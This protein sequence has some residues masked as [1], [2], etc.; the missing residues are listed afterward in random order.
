M[1]YCC[2]LIA[3]SW[4]ELFGVVFTIIAGVWTLW[5]WRKDRR[6]R[7]ADIYGQLLSIFTDNDIFHAFS[8]LIDYNEIRE[9]DLEKSKECRDGRME[10][11]DKVLLFLNQVCYLREN[12]MMS[13]KEVQT[14]RYPLLRTLTNET[15]LSYIEGLQRDIDKDFMFDSLMAYA[16]TIGKTERTESEEVLT[17]D[18]WRGYLV[19]HYGGWTHVAESVA[20]RVNTICERSGATI[21][22]LV[23]TVEIAKDYLAKANQLFPDKSSAQIASFRTAIRHCCNAKH[24]VWLG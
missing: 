10:R 20:S 13:E 18:K 9:V 7:C 12:L 24:G 19:K 15:V 8:E 21:D 14:F 16:L 2:T 17:D 23:K 4:A 11:L 3:N 6:D 5:Q 1:T 22:E